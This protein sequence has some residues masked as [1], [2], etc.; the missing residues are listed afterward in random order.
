MRWIALLDL[1]FLL[2]PNWNWT[3]ATPALGVTDAV[4]IAVEAVT[5]FA[6]P[7]V[8]VGGATS[9]APMSHPEPLGRST[10]RSSVAGHPAPVEGT[11]SIAALPGAS[12]MV[13]AGPA[14][15]APL[16]RAPSPPAPPSPAELDA[17]VLLVT[18]REPSVLTM[19]PP[20]NDEP[21][22]PPVPAVGPGPPSPPRPPVPASLPWNVL[23][24]TVMV[25]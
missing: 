17:K 4:T 25:P 15:P 22:V 7:V 11:A 16:A 8:A 5:D 6:R 2:V 19:P 1:Y 10:P 13:C 9:Y 3:V 23:S 14:L 20:P 24:T 18:D 21:P 12:E